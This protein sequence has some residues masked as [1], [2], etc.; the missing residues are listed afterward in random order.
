MTK[1]KLDVLVN[2][3]NRLG[4]EANSGDVVPKLQ[5]TQSNTL[6]VSVT[7]VPP[8]LPPHLTLSSALERINYKL[9][10]ISKHVENASYTGNDVVSE[11]DEIIAAIAN[12]QVSSKV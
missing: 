6:I 12:F 4:L 9:R 5:S 8:Y 7:S 11:L 2:S 1:E 10:D 3:W